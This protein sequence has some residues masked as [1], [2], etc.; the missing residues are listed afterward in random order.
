M[1]YLVCLLL[2]LM[3]SPAFAYTVHIHVYGTYNGRDIAFEVDSNIDACMTA[4][5][6]FRA[7]EEKEAIEYTCFSSSGKIVAYGEC[8][9][10]KTVVGPKNI[11]D[12]KYEITPVCSNNIEQK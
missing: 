5:N 10:K 11:F 6:E 9:L 1:K 2:S 4:A 8:K 7:R 12:T 3:A